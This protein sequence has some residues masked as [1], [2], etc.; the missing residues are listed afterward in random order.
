M[1]E[2]L[3]TNDPVLISFVQATLANAGIEALVLDTHASIL[4]GSASAIPR[5]IM[6]VDG[7]LE[8]ARQILKVKEAELNGIHILD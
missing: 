6:V 5:R 2:L 3:K 8:T 7:D 4:E 1:I